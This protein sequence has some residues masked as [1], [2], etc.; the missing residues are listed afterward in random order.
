MLQKHSY[1][2]PVMPLLMGFTPQ[3]AI[4]IG[5]MDERYAY[6]SYMQITEYNMATIGTKCLKQVTTK[7]TGGTLPDKKNE[8][9]DT[10]VK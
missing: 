2:S 8:L 10:K 6:D 1:G 7:S 5:E 9:D 3:T 4:E